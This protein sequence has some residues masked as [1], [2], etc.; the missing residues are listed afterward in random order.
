MDK[1]KKSAISKDTTKLAASPLTVKPKNVKLV[2]P[3]G[4]WGWVI[5]LA[6]SINLMVLPT[7]V[8][9]FGVLVPFIIREYDSA[10]I[11]GVS[12]IPGIAVAV[13]N[14]TGPWV[15]AMLKIYSHRRLASIG[16]VTMVVAIIVSSYAGSM[17]IWYA[18]YGLLLGFGCSLS[19][20]MG[21][22]LLQEY[23][24]KRRHMAN[25]ITMAG[26]SIGQMLIPLIMQ[27]LFDGF[28]LRGGLLIY[29]AVVLQGL[30][31][32]LLFQPSRWHW[33]LDDT[34]NVEVELLEKQ[35]EPTPLIRDVETLSALSKS[36]PTSWT[37]NVFIKASADIRRVQQMDGDINRM[38]SRSVASGRG[39]THDSDAGPDS[40]PTSMHVLNYLGSVGSLVS[41]E[42]AIAHEMPVTMSLG[43]MR[44]QLK[45]RTQIDKR[46]KWLQ[47]MPRCPPASSILDLNLIKDPFFIIMSVA[48]ALGRLTYQQFNVLVPSFA[49]SV[50]VPPTAAAS[51]VTILAASDT[52]ARLAIPILAGKFS[53]YIT[54]LTVF[55]IEFAIC[56]IGSFALAFSTD[57]VGM[58]ISC[59]IYGIG[60]GGITGMQ[61]VVIVQTLGMDKLAAAFGLNL[62]I[63]GLIVFPGIIIIGYIQVLTGSFAVCFH[64][65]G[66]VCIMCC[67]LWAPLPMMLRRR[68]AN[69]PK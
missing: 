50:G 31:A 69:L 7:T 67:C 46:P 63:G 62:F 18:S 68:N 10:N 34:P 5:I 49:Q 57:F 48:M 58:V 26:G 24:L 4:A 25:G 29:S 44:K 35:Q 54:T 11:A 12:W 36:R 17:L 15:S 40:R 64:I 56:G 47:F 16:S 65:V 43:Q 28:G 22:L 41:L 53:K 14:L 55:L 2:P 33:K 39:S 21:L 30:V 27:S 60:V 42:P 13:L 45:T 61:V 1:E 66:G 37:G 19:G 6:T 38:R 32:S 52:V 3:D 9:C 8:T 23:F 59:I 51:L 20:V